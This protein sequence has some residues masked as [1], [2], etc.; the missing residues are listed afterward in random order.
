MEQR[1]ILPFAALSLAL[2]IGGCTSSQ[3]AGKETTSQQL[4]GTLAVS[5][6][7][8]AFGSVA[9]GQSAS[10]N[11]TVTNQGSAPVSI[12]QVTITGQSFSS[13]SQSQLPASVSPSGT[14]T[15]SV[16]FSPTGTGAAS[17]QM[18]ITSDS[19]SN[20]NILVG[21]SG[22]GTAT[23]T[24]SLSSLACTSASVSGATTDSCTVAL[25]S[26]AST[27]GLS[28]NLSSSNSSV[29]VPASVTVAAGSSSASFGATVAA[30]SSSQTATLTAAAGGATQ[31]FTI[32]LAAAVPTLSINATTITFGN[33]E[34]NS[35]S[36]QSLTL[37]SIGTVPVTV[38]A[39]TAS[40]TG[41]SVSG[42]TFPLT[43]TS[44]QPVT[45][46]VQFDP[47]TAGAVTGSLTVTS[48]SSTDPTV[49]ISLSGAGVSIAYQV[50][51]S[52]AAPASGSDAVSNYNV[53][54]APSGS[55]S[56]Q[57]MNPSPLPST[58][59][60]YV[61]TSVQDGQTYDYIVESV[62]AKGVPSDPSNM[63]ILSIP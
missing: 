63:A 30:V 34:L 25:S 26:A 32:Q 12:S 37:T 59:T 14:F 27:G 28:V 2:V 39:A 1:R 33:V 58:Q 43:V 7:T 61:D 15:F 3:P 54:R 49:A 19:S 50:N 24:G 5:S 23:A 6:Q 53:Y 17:G 41:F 62:D 56:F 13:A 11:V 42:A 8:V 10:A 18:T 16:Q 29:T 52:W 21:L 9:V 45:L 47:T 44:D 38:S 36:I 51:L 40:G 55:T 60:T 4:T 35:P 22:T 48:N 20:S 57:Q 31:N 46:N